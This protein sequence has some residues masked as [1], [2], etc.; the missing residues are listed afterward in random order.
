VGVPPDQP[1]YTLRRVWLSKEEEQGY[2]YGFANEALWPLCHIA[3]ARP[4]FDF[5]DWEQYR[6]VNHKFAEAVLEEVVGEPA[7]VFVQ[8]YHFALLPRM[9]REARP[10]LVIVHFWHIP[11]PH[12][13]TFRVCPW[14]EEILDG[15][16]GNDLLSFHVQDHCNNFLETVDRGIESRVDP[17]QFS[18]TRNGRTTL[19]QP[20]PISV[21]PCV[22]A[23]AIPT[24][25]E[26]HERRLRKRLHLRDELLLVGVDRVDYT[27]G[28][29]ERFRAIDRLLELHPDL[30]GAFSFVQIG[31]PSRTHIVTYRRLN[32]ELRELADEINWRHGTPE[33]RPIVF[34]NEYVSPEEIYLLDRLAVGCV[35]SSLHDGMNLVAKEFVA[36]RDDDDGVLI[37]SRF[38]GASHDLRDALLVNPYDVEDVAAAI[39]RAV[40][41]PAEER[42]DRM[43]RMRRQVREH[44]IYGWAGLL[45]DE[46]ARIPRVPDR[47]VA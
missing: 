21:D 34:L 3:Y 20:H 27:K 19:I 12:R 39:Y 47:R 29:P 25:L 17:A 46:L 26:T 37:L 40:T 14:Q 6:I 16:L 43:D 9:L 44:N 8:D 15:L 33:W 2:Y 35:V 32:D 4:K 10:D 24:D 31:A 7:I 11:W 36:A 23:T 22:V 41:I 28:I 45:L 18:I 38:A 13:E 30:R 1:A 5:N 42:R